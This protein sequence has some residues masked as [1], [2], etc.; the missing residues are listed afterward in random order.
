MAYSD[1]TPGNLVLK[2][3]EYSKKDFENDEENGHKNVESAKN[4]AAFTTENPSTSLKYPQKSAAKLWFSHLF[5]PC[6]SLGTH[7]E[8]WRW[9]LV[10]TF[11]LSTF[12]LWAYLSNSLCWWTGF[13]RK[14]A[15]GSWFIIQSSEF[16]A[17]Q[18][19]FSESTCQIPSVD[20]PALLK[21][22]THKD[23]KISKNIPKNTTKNWSILVAVSFFVHDSFSIIRIYTRICLWTGLLHPV[24]MDLRIRSI[25]STIHGFYLPTY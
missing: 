18:S 3:W 8:T 25:C 2:K 20:E 13:T 16:E 9:F 24:R 22:M 17:D 6:F 21:E 5:Y 4:L 15:C 1:F 11:I 19:V 23:V 12:F 14:F 10:F 7:R